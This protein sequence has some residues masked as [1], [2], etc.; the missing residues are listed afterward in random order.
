MNAKIITVWGAGGS[1]KTTVASN[2]AAAIA[3]RNFMTCIISSKLCY[4]ELQS[5][6]G[7]RVEQ[8]KGIYK[9]ISGG[10]STRNM[11]EATDNPNLFFLSP[12]NVF[13]AMLLTAVSAESVKELIEDCAV[14]F[15]YIIIDG[16]EELN[17]PVSSIGLTMSNKIIR[18]YRV[19]AK[20]CIWHNSMENLTDLLHIR[21]KT[22]TVINGYD[23]TCDKMSFL[24]GIKIKPD[25]EL[26]YVPNCSTLINSGKLIINNKV[27]GG[28]YKK[29][30]QKI[31]SQALLG[32]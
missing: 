7:K 19:C 14:R 23:K 24:G 25:F 32:G 13:D 6:F 1:G 15:D 11:F 9:A 28:L 10:G 20:D 5:V 16:S 30:M 31:A 29:T 26:P 12:P 3:D 27:G 4:G 21:N 17:N 8:D 18:V 22:V 2:L